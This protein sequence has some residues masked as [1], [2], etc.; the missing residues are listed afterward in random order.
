[1][2]EFKVVLFM[3][4]SKRVAAPWENQEQDPRLG[5]RVLKVVTDWLKTNRPNYSVEVLDPRDLKLP[6]IE[7]PQF[8]YK[9]GTS[10][11][12]LDALAKKV[13]DAD[14][15]LVLSAEYNHSIP[16]PLSNLMSYFGGSKFAYKPSGIITYSPGEYGGMRAAMALRPF[17]SEL[18]C[19]PVSS[20]CAFSRANET[21]SP[22]GIPRD[23][24]V[25]NWPARMIEQ[26]DFWLE[27][28]KVQ[29]EKNKQ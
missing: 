10:P 8:Y 7:G 14:G 29:R 6:V 15:F 11:H 26:F 24:K 21:I 1:M 4:S 20:I 25:A 28:S 18:G 19:L 13:G 9:E 16:A 27:A 5:S 22:E 23:E 17:L 3:G 12:D 2:S